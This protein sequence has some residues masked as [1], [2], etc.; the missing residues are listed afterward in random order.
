[1]E[2]TD[3]EVGPIQKTFETLFARIGKYFQSAPVVPSG[4]ITETEL[5]IYAQEQLRNT[6]NGILKHYGFSNLPNSIRMAAEADSKISGIYR[7]DN[8]TIYTEKMID[9]SYRTFNFYSTFGPENMKA[10]FY[11][12]DIRK[13]REEIQGIL[14][15]DDIWYLR[16]QTYSGDIFYERIEQ[17]IPRW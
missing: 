7:S 17:Q 6:L 15:I 1:M 3:L 4:S 14:T 8:I 11:W 13:S 9:G 16:I 2:P 5:N 10:S 12:L